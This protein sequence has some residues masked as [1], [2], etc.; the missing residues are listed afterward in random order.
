MGAFTP[1]PPASKSPVN[2]H[3]TEDRLP[4]SGG[5]RESDRYSWRPNTTFA[6]CQCSLF[7]HIRY[8]PMTPPMW[9]AQRDIGLLSRVQRPFS[10]HPLL[11][12]LLRL[13]NTRAIGIPGRSFP[14][15]SVIWVGP[16]APHAT[17]AGSSVRWCGD[18]HPSPSLSQ[19]QSLLAEHTRAPRLICGAASP[20][21]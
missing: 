3:D 16:R 13:L 1:P 5:S 4:V 12:H 10:I 7:R 11:I 21:T 14:A 18:L 15:S 9:E 17:G 19:S 20:Y 8:K 6:S 2:V